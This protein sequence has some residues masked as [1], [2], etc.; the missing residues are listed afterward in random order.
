MASEDMASE[1][2]DSEEHWAKFARDTMASSFSPEM[3]LSGPVP[4]TRDDELA[5]HPS[6]TKRDGV[7]ITFTYRV[8][9]DDESVTLGGASVRL[10]ALMAF[11]LCASIM[12]AMPNELEKMLLRV[13][14]GDIDQGLLEE[15]AE[16][17]EDGEYETM[18]SMPKFIRE[19][20]APVFMS[21]EG[22]E[23]AK[24]MENG[25]TDATA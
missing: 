4:L 20:M 3:V 21:D 17:V 13:R 23:H 5:R 12:Q 10:N 14:A 7:G 11:E 2:M 1:D 15:L 16:Y 25:G 19:P 18:I 22:Y 8:D 24:R 6:E 9:E